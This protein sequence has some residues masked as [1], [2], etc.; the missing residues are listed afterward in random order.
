[1][2]S[3]SVIQ[4]T[5]SSSSSISAVVKMMLHQESLEAVRH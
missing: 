3:S 2:A 5:H 1:M 4:H